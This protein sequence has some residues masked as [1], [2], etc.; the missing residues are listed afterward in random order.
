[1]LRQGVSHIQGGSRDYG[2]TSP[3]TLCI[4]FVEKL[5]YASGGMPSASDKLL[6]AFDATSTLKGTWEFP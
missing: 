1:M 6:R 2:P 5:P 3:R 4:I